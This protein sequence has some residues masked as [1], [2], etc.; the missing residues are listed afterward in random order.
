MSLRPALSQTV[1]KEKPVSKIKNNNKLSS[2][3]HPP[4]KNFKGE[5]SFQ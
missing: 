2:T 4:N 5:G 1:S 3:P